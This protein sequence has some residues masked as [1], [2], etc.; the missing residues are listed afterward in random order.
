MAERMV[1]MSFTVPPSLRNDLSYLSVR[2]GVTKSALLSL[3]VGEPLGDLRQLV[4]DIPET[5]TDADVRRFRGRSREIIEQ[6]VG[7]LQDLTSD[8]LS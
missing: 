5:P 3:L 8:L 1:R 2:L 7:N 6:R 4:E